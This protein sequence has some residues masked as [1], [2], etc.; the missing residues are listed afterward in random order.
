MSNHGQADRPPHVD[1]TQAGHGW[2]CVNWSWHEM[3]TY[4][5]NVAIAR[6]NQPMSI[7]LCHMVET[8]NDLLM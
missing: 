4:A 3:R 2:H 8:G 6:G 5:E 1:G 7:T